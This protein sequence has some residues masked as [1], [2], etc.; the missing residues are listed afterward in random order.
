MK[1]HP[2]LNGLLLVLVISNFSCTLS[3]SIPKPDH[4]VIVIE[5]NHGYDQIIGTENAP[6]INQLA[7]EG[8]LFTNS[9]AVTH[10]S[11]PNYLAFFS[12]SLQGVTGDRCLKD[13][14]PFTTPNLGAALIKAGYTFKG[15]A[16]TLPDPSFMD[17]YY[18]KVPGYDYA[19]KHAPWVNWI[20]DK[21]NN[22][23]EAVSQPLTNFPSDYNKLPTVSFVIP[24]EGNDMHNIGLNGDTAA[25]LRADQWLKDHLLGY[26]QWAK[27]HNSLFI[28]TFDEDQGD[29]LDPNRIPTIMAGAMVEPGK[30]NDSI[31]HYSVL[32]TLEDMYHLAPSGNAVAESI[33]SIWK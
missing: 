19:R 23:P 1:K 26:I 4:V 12:G 3:N 8:A 10:P 31:D 9:H 2:L 16:E 33:K 6:Y 30:Y 5:E 27:T 24:N 21:Q 29:D 17:C 18:N 7:D 13:T 25:I 20:G 28:L 11:Q 32:R 15:Y 14:T 22:M